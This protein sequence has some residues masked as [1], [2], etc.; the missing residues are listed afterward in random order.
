MV[1]AGLGD[2]ARADRRGG[3]ADLLHRRRSPRRVVADMAA[4]GGLVTRADLAALPARSRPRWRCAPAR[5]QLRTNP[6]PAIGGPVLAAM[7]TCSATGRGADWTE[8]DVAQSWSRS[9]ARCSTPAATG[10]TWRPTGRAAA[11]GLLA[12]GRLGRAGLTEHRA[13]LGGRRRRH[14]LRDHHVLRLRLGR[15]RAGHRDLAEQL[16]RRARAQPG[17]PRARAGRP[18]GINM[19]PTVGRHADGAVL[20]IGSP[21]ADRITTALLQ[22]LAAFANGGAHAA[23]GRRPAAAARAPPRRRRAR[24]SPPG[25]G[26]GGPAA[27]RRSTCRSAGTTRTRCTSAASAAALRR[28]DGGLEAAGDPRRAGVVAVSD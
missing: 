7:L 17:R 3:R 12:R 4:R 18:A 9:S 13:R 22:V 8:D 25:R 1:V 15:D 23:V 6:P 21:G 28:S 19:A 5:W 26:G 2:T 10:S 20:A 14:R 16:P 24:R 27:A 11:L